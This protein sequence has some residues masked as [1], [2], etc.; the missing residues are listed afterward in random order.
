MYRARPPGPWQAYVP[1]VAADALVALLK[2]GL[3]IEGSPALF[4][5]DAPG[6]R[7]E[8]YLPAGF[9]LL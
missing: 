4:C 5:A 3:R 2:A 8:C 6:P 1:G 9:A 7:L